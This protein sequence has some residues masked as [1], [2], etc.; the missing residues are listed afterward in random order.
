MDEKQV[1]GEDFFPKGKTLDDIIKEAPIFVGG[2]RVEIKAEPV[3]PQPETKVEEQ[4]K[5]ETKPVVESKPVGLTPEKFEELAKEY[6]ELRD[7]KKYH[8]DYDQWEKKLRQKSQTIPWF[9]KLDPEKQEIVINKVL[10]YVYGKEEL[11][12]A[13]KELVDDVMKNVTVED[14]VIKDQDGIEVK[15]SKAELLPHVR[16]AVELTLNNAVPEMATMRK[17]VFE[18]QDRIKELENNNKAMEGRLG[19]IEFET[20]VSRHPSLD[21]KRV[22]KDESILDAVRRV[23]E[24]GESHPEYRKLAKLQAV[25]TQAQVKKWSPEN[26]YNNLFG[27]EER[28]EK[29]VKRTEETVLKNQKESVQETPSGDKPKDKADWEKAM[30]SV[31]QRHK[32]IEEMFKK[33]GA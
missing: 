18:E 23:N 1:T 14:M 33:A 25:A 5:E 28:L 3:E 31:G 26:A 30:G 11:P 17:R 12:K 15:V 24:A 13:P 10:P 9:E 6:P 7:H 4:P 16:K 21:I 32:V 22:S 29:D 8:D 20:L 2:K 27:D 19:E